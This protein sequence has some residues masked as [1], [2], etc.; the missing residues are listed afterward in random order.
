MS[1][2]LRHRIKAV[3]FD[4]DDTLWDFEATMKTAYH[5]FGEYLHEMNL[6]HAAVVMNDVK[7]VKPRMDV[8]VAKQ[9]TLT[10][11]IDYTSIRREL[12]KTVFRE[13]GTPLEE[14]VETTIHEKWLV[15]RAASAH[16]FPGVIE[17]LQWLKQEGIIIGA[18]TNGNA[19]IRHIPHLPQ[20]L[21]NFQVN[22]EIA[23]ANKPQPEMYLQAAN[24]AG[25]TDMS[26]ILFVGDNFENDVKG[27]KLVG[28]QTVFLDWER[29]TMHAADPEVAKFADWIVH[30]IIQ[31]EDIVK[32]C[33]L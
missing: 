19:D 23:S 14:H 9:Q 22:P 20:D 29:S 3:F 13:L 24:L 32:E 30:D 11:F 18:V 21:F 1:R 6:P 27:P 28:M 33:N 26:E 25:I 8:I 17:L 2:V 5:Q 7:K 31:V 15:L 12:H 16:F 10:T 4:L